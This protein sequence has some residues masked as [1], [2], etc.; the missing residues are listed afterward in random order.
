MFDGVFPDYERVIP[1]NNTRVLKVERKAFSE[2]VAR[3]AAIS[4]ER[5]R[6]VKMSLK[7][8]SLVLS[9]NS[10]ERGTA[11]EELDDNV[12]FYTSEELEIGFQARYLVDIMEQIE[13]EAEFVFADSVAPVIVRSA[14]TSSVLYVIMPMRV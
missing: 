2:A 3:V 14:G 8:G 5:S 4:R 13:N 6:P 9:A 7:T 1:Q 10:P 11:K 12:V